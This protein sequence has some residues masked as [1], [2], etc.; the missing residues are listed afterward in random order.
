MDESE[1]KLD[2]QEMKSLNGQREKCIFRF[3]LR[4]ITTMIERTHMLRYA[5]CAVSTVEVPNEVSLCIYISGCQNQ[6]LDCHYPEL[7]QWDYGDMLSDFFLDILDAYQSLITCVCFMGEGDLSVESRNE[8]VSYAEEV[9]KRK[10]SAALYSGRDV[11]VEEW[12]KCFYYVKLGR[13][14]PERGALIDRTTNQRLY[15]LCK[16]KYVD[17]TEFFWK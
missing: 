9:K 10:L 1:K 14:I 6:C 4:Y 8:L 2:N 12:M 17:I 11:A 7:Q 5:E 3:D 15:K 16:K 13:F